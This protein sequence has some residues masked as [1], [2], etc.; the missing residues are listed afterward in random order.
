MREAC[1]RW[2]SATSNGTIGEPYGVEGGRRVDIDLK[3]HHTT[4]SLYRFGESK[5]WVLTGYTIDK[6]ADAKGRGSDLSNAMQNDPI[7]TR[8]ELGAALKSVAKLRNIFETSKENVSKSPEQ[9]RNVEHVDNN[10]L[11]EEHGDTKYSIVKDEALKKELEDSK[12]ITVYRA[13]VVDENGKSIVAFLFFFGS[14][15]AIFMTF[16]RYC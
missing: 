15:G 12:K 3:D 9:D 11:A 14:L 13:M 4:V 8:A 2:G 5:S 16:A 7:R 10:K 1:C 6:N